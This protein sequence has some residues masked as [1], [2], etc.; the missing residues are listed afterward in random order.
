MLGGSLLDTPIARAALERGGHLRVGLEDWDDG[1]D[2]RRTDR[3]RGRSSV[4]A[5]G[6]RGR[7]RQRRRRDVLGL[8]LS[9]HG[10]RT[11]AVSERKLAH[12][13][14]RDTAAADEPLDVGAD[15]GLALVGV[16]EPVFE[17]GAGAEAELGDA[18]DA[19]R[20]RACTCVRTTFWV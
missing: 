9:R 16:V 11:L 3:G 18:V 8:A 2:E 14:G 20:R 19:R 1:T 12:E 13:R 4:A 15:R 17:I 6:R 7:D 10:R 5:V